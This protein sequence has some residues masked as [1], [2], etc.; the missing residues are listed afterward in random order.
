MSN[1]HQMFLST[2]A[3]CPF[4]NV[5]EIQCLDEIRT[6]LCLYQV[7]KDVMWEVAMK[8]EHNQ[9]NVN[10]VESLKRILRPNNNSLKSPGKAD[11]I[12]RQ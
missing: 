1:L 5:I 8:R 6:S 7:L 3:F 4:L 2:S 12:D 9:L 10:K 11:Q